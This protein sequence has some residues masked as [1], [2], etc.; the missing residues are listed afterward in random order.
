LFHQPSHAHETL[1]TVSGLPAGS[2]IRIATLDSYDGVVFAVG[3]DQVVS[4]SGAFVR[5][6]TA[7]DRSDIA[8]TPAQITITIDAY[9]GVW[10]PTV[11]MLESV[12]FAGE[13][14][15]QLLDSF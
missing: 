15:A 13:R 2:R 8:G 14:S 10:L 1:M 6:P 12:D 7:L 11:G 5:V 9:E 4:E 3:S